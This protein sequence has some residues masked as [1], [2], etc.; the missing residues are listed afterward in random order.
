MVLAGQQKGAG[1][2]E[3]EGIAGAE[4]PGVPGQGKVTAPLGAVASGVAGAALGGLV[5]AN[6][7]AFLKQ[8]LNSGASKGVDVSLVKTAADMLS[9]VKSFGLTAGQAADAARLNALAIAT[10]EWPNL[11]SPWVRD[12]MGMSPELWGMFYDPVTY[13]L[14]PLN[15]PLAPQT[16][17]SG[18]SGRPG[19]TSRGGGYGGGGVSRSIGS[20][21]L[22]MGLINWRI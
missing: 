20:G 3:G 8:G 18:G 17:Q 11:M 22:T 19:Y 15:S 4:K 10:G 7:N 14:R 5:M 1:A 16:V 13:R 6:A 21:G 2:K 12:A 9:G